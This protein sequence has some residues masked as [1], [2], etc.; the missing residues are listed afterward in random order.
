M[1]PF[2]YTYKYRCE[3]PR[4]DERVHKRHLLRSRIALNKGEKKR[5]ETHPKEET[6]VPELN[7]E[8]PLIVV[9]QTGES[10]VEKVEG[11]KGGQSWDVDKL[12]GLKTV[13]CEEEGRDNLQY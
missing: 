13:D 10:M 3:E 5:G 8:L 9:M 2:L 11:P 1:Y 12:E 7:V 6:F 4:T